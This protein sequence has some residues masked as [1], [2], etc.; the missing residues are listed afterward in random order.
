MLVADVVRG[1]AVLDGLLYVVCEL[2]SVIHVFDVN[3]H[4]RLD[5]IT[6][7]NLMDPN[8]IAACTTMKHLYVADCRTDDTDS[9]GCI[10]KVSPTGKST[11][12]QLDGGVS[13]YSLSIRKG[14]ILV[15]PLNAKELLIYNSE[16]KVRQKIPLPRLEPRH[17][18]ETGHKTVIVCHWGR[19]NAARVF[20]IG[21]FDGSGKHLKTFS[22]P[23][24]LNDFPHVCLDSGGR[25]LVVDSWN[26]RVI[27]LN[28][29]LNLERILVDHLDNSPY[30]MCYIEQTGQLF[31]GESVENVRVFAVSFPPS[32]ADPTAAA[33]RIKH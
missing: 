3:T 16:R 17:A 20:Q 33:N 7:L 21:E 14:R 4:R 9:T 6:V 30:R 8:D 13:P 5:D 10:W 18:A 19:R 31:V 26:S 32:T 12:W 22:G 23:D 15:T 11:K 24:D 27:L 29:D 25:V 2:S 28:K 1:V